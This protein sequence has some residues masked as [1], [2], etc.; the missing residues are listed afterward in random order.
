[1]CSNLYWKVKLLCL[2][3][4]CRLGQV[5]P[6]KFCC[7]SGWQHWVTTSWRLLVGLRVLWFL[8]QLRFQTAAICVRRRDVRVFKRHFKVGSSLNEIKQKSTSEKII[9]L[10]GSRVED[11]YI[12]VNSRL[13]LRFI[14]RR[15]SSFCWERRRILLLYGKSPLIQKKNKM[16]HIHN[17]R[18][19][20]G[21][22]KFS[23]IQANLHLFWL[24]E[25]NQADWS[26]ENKPALNT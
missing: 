5:R 13:L 26:D 12:P 20:F 19:Y 25:C 10:A 14:K 23:G 24:V 21:R 7:R 16:Q 8:L 2:I 11:L 9:L 15:V 6:D 18:H 17:A 3:P 4:Q 22:L 1:M